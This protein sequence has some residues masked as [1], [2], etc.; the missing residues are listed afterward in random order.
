MKSCLSIVIGLLLC[1]GNGTA[2]G[3]LPP[4]QLAFHPGHVRFTLEQLSLP[5]HEHMGLAGINYLLDIKPW[6]YAGLGVYGAVTGKRGGFFTGGIETGVRKRL[7]HDWLVDAGMFVGG[8]GGGAAPQGGGL[9]LRPHV[10]V[11][12]DTR[13]GRIGA[14]LSWVKFPN[15]AIDSKQVA[16][17]Y[18]L[19]VHALFAGGW[20]RDD[21]RTPSPGGIELR[22]AAREFS[23]V[24]Q[25]YLLPA[26]TRGRSG[27]VQDR[28]MKLLGIQWN[29]YLDRHTY[30]KLETSG[31]GG[32]N[33]DGYAQLLL[34]AGHRFDLSRRNTL[35]LEAGLG[36]AGGGN[37]D[38][39][40]GVIANAGVGVQHRFDNGLLL[41][42][43]AGYIAA[44]GGEF[45]A[46]TVGVNLGY[47]YGVPRMPPPD[48]VRSSYH[49]YGP[50]YW[51]LRAAHQSYLPRGDTSRKGSTVP[52]HRRIDLIGIQADRMVG[53]HLY[54]TGQALG[55]Y[56]GGAGGYATGLL[57][58]GYI[59]PWW[60]N[61]RLELNVEGLV[62]VGGGGGLAVGGGLITQAT[63]GLNY[64]ISETTGVQL[65]YG[66]VGA[67]QGHF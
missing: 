11:A 67:P 21:G 27:T 14:N 52:D 63:A 23:L 37:V 62:G 40:G 60:K 5:Q 36:A 24:A 64:R 12:Y 6:F 10:G 59:L 16:L 15:G 2:C 35:R 44:P 41:G 13:Y 56:R 66:Y 48:V 30:L 8:G 65:T 61:S 20:L 32:G 1:L 18:E 34:G 47:A 39:G 57:G 9:M 19:P 17:S 4:G 58:A 51:R 31:A 22:S 54:V 42:L 29:R 53:R 43:N 55:A 33:S 28:N 50:R 38:T 45:K 49:T 3:A 26:G 25:T 46:A 7:G